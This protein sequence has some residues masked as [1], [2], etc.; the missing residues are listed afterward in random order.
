M[1]TSL[2]IAFEDMRGKAGS[3]VV[4]KGRSGLVVK[5]RVSGKN[6]RTAPQQSVRYA[7]AKAAQNYRNLTPAQVDEWQAYAQTVVKTNPVDGRVY[8]PTANTAFMALAAKFLQVSP[9]G[10]VPLDPPAGAFLGDSVTVTATSSAAVTV[11][12]A[13]SGPNAAG[14]TT[15]L[16]LQSLKSPNRTPNAKGYRTKAFHV[17][18]NTGLKNVTVPPGHYAAAYRFVKTATGQA[19]P[20]QTLPV[21]V[22]VALAVQ[23]GLGKAPKKAA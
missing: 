8:H 12:F 4:T 11:T 15:E 3:V 14:V 9:N 20:L 6:P 2:S 1:K 5:P 7:L 23:P 16:L 17:F 22:T 21:V 19:S 10:T 13:S 18:T